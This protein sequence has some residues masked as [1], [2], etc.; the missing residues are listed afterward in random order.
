[1]RTFAI[2]ALGLFG[3]AAVAQ[4]LPSFEEVDG[5]GDGQVT[6][7]EAAAI[8]ALDFT[9][10]DTNQDGTLSREEYTAAADAQ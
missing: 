6:R 10:A 5:N 4:G 8:E 1:M 3:V 7:E 9:A 2:L